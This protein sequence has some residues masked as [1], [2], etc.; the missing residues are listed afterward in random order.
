MCI[1]AAVVSVNEVDLSCMLTK[2]VNLGPG[3]TEQIFVYFAKNL[4]P[5]ALDK[6]TR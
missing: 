3:R 5:V 6:C 4:S 2:K 1:A